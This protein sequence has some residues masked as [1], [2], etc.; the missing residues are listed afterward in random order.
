V[1]NAERAKKYLTL[2]V[3][4]R[5]CRKAVHMMLHSVVKALR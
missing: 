5:S 4:K 3:Y 2:G 1:L